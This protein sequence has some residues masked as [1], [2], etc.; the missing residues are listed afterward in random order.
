MEK[1]I[2]TSAKTGNN[3]KSVFEDL[4]KRILAKEKLK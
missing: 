3:V 2:P 1:F 4:A